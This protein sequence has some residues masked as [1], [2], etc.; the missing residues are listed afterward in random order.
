MMVFLVTVS[1]A[2]FSFCFVFVSLSLLSNAKASVCALKQNYN[3][4]YKTTNLLLEKNR[5]RKKLSS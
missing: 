2:P 3:N 1:Q 4:H 5:I